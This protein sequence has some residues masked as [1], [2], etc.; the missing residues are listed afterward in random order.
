MV[1]HNR[2]SLRRQHQPTVLPTPAAHIRTHSTRG[3]CGA[4]IVIFIDPTQKPLRQYW[5]LKINNRLQDRLEQLEL[6]SRIWRGEPRYSIFR[7]RSQVTRAAFQR[8]SDW[9]T[10]DG[11]CAWSILFTEMLKLIYSPNERSNPAGFWKRQASFGQPE[12]QGFG[13]GGNAQSIVHHNP[14]FS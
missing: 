8:L 6:F 10:T 13:G 7:D 5:A 12:T 3:K 1:T 11:V 9:L 4:C 14:Q 2:C